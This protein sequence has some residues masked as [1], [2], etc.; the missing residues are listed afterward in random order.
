M[1]EWQPMT[2]SLAKY[3]TVYVH[4]P[5]CCFV[6]RVNIMEEHR[7]VAG[8][9]DIILDFRNTFSSIS[10]LK[11]TEV[12]SRMRPSQVMEIRGSDPD[13]RKDLLK[14]LPAA[15]YEVLKDGESY[16]GPD[17]FRVRIRKCQD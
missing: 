6:L 12:F 4:W 9:E 13:I 16:T 7:E 2:G 8:N 15:S 1:P 3:F 17:F 10:L 14:V 5:G 11:M